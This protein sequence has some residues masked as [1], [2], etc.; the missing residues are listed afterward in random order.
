MPL[1]R[2]DFTRT[3]LLAGT[4]T[5]FHAGRAADTPPNVLF[6]TTDQMRGDCIGA[7]GHPNVRTP[8][9]DRM[10]REGV[11]F[12]NG[13]A[14]GPVCVP[15]R[16]SCFSGQHPHEH[17]S[18]TNQDGDKLEWRGSMLAY[19]AQQGYRTGWV[20]KNHTFANDALANLDYSD[21]RSREPFRA[22]NGYVPP[23]WHSTV[24]WPEEECYPHVNTQSALGFLDRAGTVDPF[25]LHVSYFDPHP[26]Y[27]APARFAAR[28]D[29]GDMVLPARVDP[30]AL[31]ARLGRFAAAL[32][33]GEL[34]R[35]DITET[36]RYY[37]AQVEWGV[38]GP[39]GRLLHALEAR[40]L[41]EN[42]VV[43][44]TADHGDFMGD[45]GMVRKGMYLYDSLLH[46][47]LIW[48][49]PGRIASGTRT[50]ALA[51]SADLFP[52]LA[53]L[54]G[55][56]PPEKASGV[57]V[58]DSLAG[59]SEGRRHLFTSAA[60]G[61]LGADALPPNLTPDDE[62]AKPRHTRVLNPTMSPT[63]RTKMVRTH[64]WKYILNE[65]EPPELY[66]IAKSRPTE[67]QNVAQSR[68][69]AGIRRSLEREL[70]AW[71][72]WWPQPSGPEAGPN[73]GAARRSTALNRT[74]RKAQP[75]SF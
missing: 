6:I 67:R 7:V 65:S 73:H 32:G 27:M 10:A 37:Y 16:K 53:D 14:S 66:R 30:S 70:S 26:P 19:F 15:T 50:N 28:Y 48:W 38:D 49:A 20:G 62:D 22:Y 2:R 56:P 1:S 25:F 42:T 9:L 54:T 68:G 3:A 69:H 59:S 21:I 29:S 12:R 11:L 61:D 40:G 33:F 63:Y 51:Q 52:T 75:P 4:T 24:Y 36:M 43:V 8:N 74:A 41:G 34:D 45:Y 39:V 13:F 23:H 55:G 46:V 5:A 47:P 60:Y 58:A 44:L 35:E 64:E 57:S 18:L 17:G 31:S 71:W 72:P